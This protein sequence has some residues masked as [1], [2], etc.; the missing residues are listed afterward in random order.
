MV[1]PQV[2][3]PPT[4]ARLGSLWEVDLAACGCQIHLPPMTRELPE[5]VRKQKGT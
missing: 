4:V 5:A 1:T 2:T 3:L